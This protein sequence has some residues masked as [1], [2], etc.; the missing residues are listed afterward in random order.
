MLRFWKVP[1]WRYFNFFKKANIEF[2]K[3][4]ILKS[5]ANIY[6]KPVSAF[7]DQYQKIRREEGEDVFEEEE[8]IEQPKAEAIETECEEIIQK[9]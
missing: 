1:K 6:D 7:C 2:D 9:I 5:V 3:K 4:D 8:E